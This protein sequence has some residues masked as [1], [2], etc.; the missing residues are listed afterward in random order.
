MAIKYGRHDLA[1]ARARCIH[2]HAEYAGALHN[3]LSRLTAGVV[4]PAALAL[5]LACYAGL[6]LAAVYISRTELRLPTL[7]YASLAA[8]SEV[9]APPCCMSACTT[10]WL[11]GCCM[12]ALGAGVQQLH[13]A[14]AAHA[15]VCVA[16]GGLGG[17]CV[18]GCRP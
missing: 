15:A 13:G 3:M 5:L 14:Q 2:V 16:G 18:A 9:R 17:A 8:G 1:R 10:Q 7:Q 11:C 4:D 12:A 6:A